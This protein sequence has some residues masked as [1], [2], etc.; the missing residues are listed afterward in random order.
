V[1][2]R[3]CDWWAEKLPDNVT[4]TEGCEVFP[5]CLPQLELVRLLTE[6]RQAPGSGPPDDPRP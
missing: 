6:R 1:S 3:C 4:C 2:L 5:R